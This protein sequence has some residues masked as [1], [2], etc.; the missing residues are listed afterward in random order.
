MQ[1]LVVLV[2]SAL[3]VKFWPVLVGGIGMIVAVYWGRRVADRH[4][5][6]IEAERRRLAGLMGRA[7]AQHNWTLQGDDRGLYD[8]YPP[9]AV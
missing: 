7:D 1:F 9:V 8:E 6:R 2:V 3:V 5:E 4:A